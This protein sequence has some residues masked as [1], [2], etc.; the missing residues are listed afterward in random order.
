MCIRGE[1]LFTIASANNEQDYRL[2]RL[3]LFTHIPNMIQT[4]Y[5]GQDLA[6]F[7]CT[8]SGS[9]VVQWN[10]ISWATIKVILTIS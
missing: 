10:K 7:T 9:H 4:H 1:I 8:G 2:I 5:G 6:R 3:P